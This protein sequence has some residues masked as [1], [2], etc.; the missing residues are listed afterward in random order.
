M[1]HIRSAADVTPFVA[2]NGERI[3]EFIGHVAGG[4]TRHSV[5]QIELPTGKA[6]VNHYHPVAEESYYILSGKGRLVMDGA[7]STLEAGQCV[8]IPPNVWHQLFNDEPETLRFIA[9]CVPA[10][11]PDCSVYEEKKE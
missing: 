6:S 5:A 4:S 2:P 11:T 1:A 3:Q 10:W 9:V 8:M 7:T